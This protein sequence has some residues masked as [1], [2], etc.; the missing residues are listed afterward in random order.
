M[1]DI[2]LKMTYI[3]AKSAFCRIFRENVQ[4]RKHT[5]GKSCQKHARSIENVFVINEL[6]DYNA[7]V[8]LAER[9]CKVL[10]DENSKLCV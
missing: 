4:K 3:F 9:E 10:V 8:S 1:I 7:V 2:R 5:K 6:F